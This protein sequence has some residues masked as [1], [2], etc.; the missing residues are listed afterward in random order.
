MQS[1]AF[2]YLKMD[3]TVGYQAQARYYGSA[4]IKFR[5]KKDHII[6]FSVLVPWGLEIFRGII[7]PTSITLLNYMHKVYYV[8][9]Y[10]TLRALWP[11][12]WDYALLQ[13]LLL[14]ELSHASTPYKVIQQN[15]QQ[16]VI[17]QKKATW[18]LTH[19][20]HPT[21]RR[22]E[23]LITAAK[24]GSLVATYNLFKPCRGGLLFRR[25]TLTWYYRTVPTQPAIILSFKGI[26]TKWPKNPLLF[27]FSIPAH[28]EKKQAILDW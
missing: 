8:Y 1:L 13:A 5:I 16:I 22:V 19:C 24:R 15:A 14:G 23:K 25:A 26:Q 21:L 11:G 17:Q 9:D 3:A 18:S 4:Y 2:E 10:A 20:I 28:Y 12:P 7:T 27:P 6:W